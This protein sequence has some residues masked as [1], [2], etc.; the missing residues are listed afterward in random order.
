MTRRMLIPQRGCGR[1][2]AESIA[3][4]TGLSVCFTGA[5][6]GT[7]DGIPITRST[8]QLL[9]NNAGLTVRDNVVKELD[10]LVVADPD[11]QSGKAKRARALGTRV[12]A[13]AVFWASIG[14]RTD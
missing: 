3:S 2:V 9:A 10:L 4:L 13:E 8:A 7:V 1:S 5:L 11:T 12:I 6:L 14:A